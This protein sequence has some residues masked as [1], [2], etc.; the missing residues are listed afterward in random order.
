MANIKKNV[1][2]FPDSFIHSL[3]YFKRKYPANNP[4]NPHA[5]SKGSDKINMLIDH[6]R[7]G[8]EGIKY[9]TR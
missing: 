8:L 9:H 6:L 4:T 2:E 7:I 5:Q 3:P 1:T